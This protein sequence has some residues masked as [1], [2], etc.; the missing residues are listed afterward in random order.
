MKP[1]RHDARQS[2]HRVQL[3]PGERRRTCSGRRESYLHEA[4]HAPQS[5]HASSIRMR[6][7]DSFPP[8]AA[9][10]PS[11]HQAVQCAMYP[12][13]RDTST[14]T[15]I[16]TAPKPSAEDAAT[17]PDTPVALIT[18]AATI[19][20]ARSAGRVAESQTGGRAGRFLSMPPGRPMP[21]IAQMLH[22]AGPTRSTVDAKST[23][24]KRPSPGRAPGD[25]DAG[26][27]TWSRPVMRNESS[28]ERPRKSCAKKPP[29]KRPEAQ[30]KL[31]CVVRFDETPGDPCG[32]DRK[33]ENG[34]PSQAVREPVKQENGK[35]RLRRASTR[36]KAVIRNEAKAAASPAEKRL[37]YRIPYARRGPPP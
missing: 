17:Y 16:P 37:L 11:G 27:G 7:G 23:G 36:R 3:I 12:F 9:T 35:R 31:R 22:Q 25:D 34:R 29:R 4:A 8:R 15:P 21:R 6:N 18:S 10:R 24:M 19:T 14:I 13:R 26:T 1:P 5:V 32:V 2:P 28:P 20:A 30:A 33:E